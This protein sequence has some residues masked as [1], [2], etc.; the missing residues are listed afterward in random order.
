MLWSRVFRGNLRHAVL[1][2][3]LRVRG[4]KH[5]RI[6]RAE[7]VQRIQVEIR[8]G[9]RGGAQVRENA[10]VTHVGTRRIVLGQ[11]WR[12]GSKAT[13]GRSRT[14]SRRELV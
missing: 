1:L 13:L 11:G 5:V 4:K 12:L 10:V 7:L 3:L 14:E 8:R 2:M 9:E 6:L